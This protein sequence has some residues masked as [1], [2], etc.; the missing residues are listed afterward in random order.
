MTNENSKKILTNKKGEIVRDAICE[1]FKEYFD[2]LLD[3][4]NISLTK[5]YTA[6]SDEVKKVFSDI[7]KDQI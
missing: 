4:K 6:S 2:D 7:W 5:I 1:S 3:I